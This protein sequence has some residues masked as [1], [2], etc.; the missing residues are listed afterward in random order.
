VTAFAAH[1]LTE[2]GWRVLESA[3]EEA[4]RLRAAAVDTQHLLAALARLEDEP[5]RRAFESMGL[6][7]AEI[8]KH[9]EAVSAP[10][11]GSVPR[12]LPFSAQAS[13]S[14]EG[15]ARASQLMQADRVDAEHVLIGILRVGGRAGEALE[16]AGLPVAEARA[17]AL[18]ALRV[19]EEARPELGGPKRTSESE[20][21]LRRAIDEAREEAHRGEAPP[22]RPFPAQELTLRA[23][24]FAAAGRD[25]EL[26]KMEEVLARG[27][28]SSLFLIGPRGCGRRALVRAYASR[29]VQ[30]AGPGYPRQQVHLFEPALAREIAPP[31]FM[32]EGA[33]VGRWLAEVLARAETGIFAFSQFVSDEWVYDDFVEFVVPACLRRWAVCV[34]LVTLDERRQLARRHPELTN[35]TLEMELGP[36]SPEHAREAAARCAKAWPKAERITV[37]GTAVEAVVNLA[38]RFVADAALPGS[39]IDA[40]ERTRARVRRDHA[41]RLPDFEKSIDAVQKRIKEAVERGAFEEAAGL[42]R[43][44]DGLLREYDGRLERLQE[45]RGTVVIGTGEI[46]KTIAEMTKKTEDEIRAAG[47]WKT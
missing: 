7:P 27:D 14:M 22:P 2:T 35:V 19:P 23:G 15:A 21:E 37:A 13:A 30:Q 9:V 25:R 33:V 1:R 17:R 26:A 47:V 42:R 3:R 32:G 34:F 40:L 43:E 28:R 46:V 5:V 11:E 29:L 44:R 18:Q 41:P 10:A 6:A 39:A 20:E 31:I 8:A 45:E 16:R 4:V 24:A 36:L 38:E 12:P